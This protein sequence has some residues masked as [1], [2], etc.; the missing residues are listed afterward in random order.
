M[1]S[2]EAT[3]LE[4]RIQRTG[5][6]AL[7]AE[8]R[9]EAMACGLSGQRLG[10]FLVAVNEIVANAIVHGGGSGRL[11]LWRAAADLVCEV[12]DSGPGLDQRRVQGSRP[13]PLALGGRGL[14]LA[15]ALVD[16]MTISNRGNGTTVRLRISCPSGDR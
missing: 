11:L 3:L 14:W 5:I 7:R 15:R 13:G 10:D 4:R 2:P 1:P 8:V 6:T 16:S 12:S 9:R